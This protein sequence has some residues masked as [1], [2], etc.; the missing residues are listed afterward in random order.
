MI[1]RVVGLELLYAARRHA[2]SRGSRGK[3]TRGSAVGREV[4][5]SPRQ[6]RQEV[7]LYVGLH[8]L[9]RLL[10]QEAMVNPLDIVVAAAA[11]VSPE[12]TNGRSR[13]D[14]IEWIY[15]RFLAEEQ[16]GRAHV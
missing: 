16:I 7:R 15:H 5:F 6:Q 8:L 10:R 9:R 12:I 2:R 13:D 14:Y 1:E 4:R 11:S 3:I